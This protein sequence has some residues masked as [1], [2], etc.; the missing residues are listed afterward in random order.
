MLLMFITKLSIVI[1]III[2]IITGVRKTLATKF[3]AVAPNSLV[4]QY[5]TGFMLSF[6]RLEFCGPLIIFTVS[7]CLRLTRTWAA[8]SYPAF[9]LFLCYPVP[10][11]KMFYSNT[12]A[13]TSTK[14]RHFAGQR[15]NHLE[16]F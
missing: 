4:P 15:L 13:R 2:M 6:W 16:F 3:C 7:I 11:E 14:Y 10:E 8:V 9:N 1:I 12:W 5:E